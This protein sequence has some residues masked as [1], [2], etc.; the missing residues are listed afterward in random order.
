LY[1][2]KGKKIILKILHKKKK[3][4]KNYRIYN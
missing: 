3:N 2:R 1:F 4:E